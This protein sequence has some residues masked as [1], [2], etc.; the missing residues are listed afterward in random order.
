V[1]LVVV[2]SGDT[3]CPGLPYFFLK[4]L[5]LLW[6]E[7]QADFSQPLEHFPQVEQALLECTAN[8]DHVQIHETLL[9]RPFKKVSINRYNVAGAL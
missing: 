6:I 2:P 1:G 8:H 3:I 9:M 5:A 4:E 7:L